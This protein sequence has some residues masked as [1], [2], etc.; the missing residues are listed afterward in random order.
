MYPR[1]AQRER[2]RG[3]EKEQEGCEVKFFDD[4]EYKNLINELV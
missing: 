4:D 2:E 1:R 3:I